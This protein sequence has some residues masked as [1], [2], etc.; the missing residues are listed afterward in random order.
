MRVTTGRLLDSDQMKTLIRERSKR[1]GMQKKFAA[2]H[3][4][5]ATMI[6]DTLTGRRPPPPRLLDVLGLERVVMYRVKG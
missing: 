2:D 4:L 6:T 3:G 1:V 5:P